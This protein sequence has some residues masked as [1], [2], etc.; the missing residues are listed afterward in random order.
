M[1]PAGDGYYSPVVSAGVFA[2]VWHRGPSPVCPEGGVACRDLAKG[3]AVAPT[4]SAG[5]EIRMFSADQLRLII[6]VARRASRVRLS[7]IV[8]DRTGRSSLA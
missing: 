4:A 5:H 8:W 6:S 2:G 1:V 7:R 3:A